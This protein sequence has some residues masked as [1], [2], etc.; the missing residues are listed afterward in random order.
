MSF[1]VPYEF[2]DGAPL[3]YLVVAIATFVLLG[4]WLACRGHYG[5]ILVA[6]KDDELRASTLGYNTALHLVIVLTISAMLAGLAGALYAAS[7][8]FV[9]PDLLGLMLSAGSIVWVAVGGRGTLLGP[10]IGAFVVLQLEQRISSLSPD[11]WPLLI[12]I[13]FV[14]MVFLFPDGLTSV[15]QRRKQR[16]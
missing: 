3:Y 4:L 1:G 7:T 8:G 10:F 16:G 2:T 13:F 11:L 5:N 6:I 14:A 15:V 12:G 9:A